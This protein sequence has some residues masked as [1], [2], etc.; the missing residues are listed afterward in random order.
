MSLF[1]WGAH[2]N[3]ARRAFPAMGS[4]QSKSKQVLIEN[5]LTEMQ[6]SCD[7]S[8]T[9]E[10]TA[11]CNVALDGCNDAVIDCGNDAT[12]SVNCSVSQSS[13]A[14]LK[15]MQK[16]KVQATSSMFPQSADASNE[17]DISTNITNFLNST[18]YEAN[19]VSQNVDSSIVCTGSQGIKADLRNSLGI[20]SLCSLTAVVKAA[21]A[22]GQVGDTS[23]T[24]EG[25]T[26]ILIF[27]ACLLGL[28]V[29]YVLV[30]LI[31]NWIQSRAS[32][33]SSRGS[34]S[35]APAGGQTVINVNL[36][37]SAA[38]SSSVPLA[39]SAAT[40]VPPPALASASA[41]AG[42]LRRYRRA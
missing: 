6:S 16:S 28:Y 25:L 3:R 24:N 41:A 21:E 34:S 1:L 38:P 26:A 14:V 20:N 10:Q 7:A 32:N 40:A 30:N 9:T 31:K 36:P 8:T 11:S 27:L 13:S 37:A 12:E 5:I 18:C 19:N 35:A 42:G 29:V 33:S 15:A 17:Q 4:S 2:T 23:S 22:A 39:A